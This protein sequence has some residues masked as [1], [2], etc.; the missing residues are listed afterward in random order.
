MVQCY[1]I[2]YWYSVTICSCCIPYDA[3]DAFNRNEHPA[4]D[5][6]MIGI[7]T[8]YMSHTCNDVPN[9]LVALFARV[10]TLHQSLG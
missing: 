2:L 4:S 8:A 3:A 6:T 10:E 1:N 7:T 5:A 9:E